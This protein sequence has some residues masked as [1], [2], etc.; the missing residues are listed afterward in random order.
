[1]MMTIPA[2]K[3]GTTHSMALLLPADFYVIARSLASFLPMMV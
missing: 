2:V 3:F 1:M